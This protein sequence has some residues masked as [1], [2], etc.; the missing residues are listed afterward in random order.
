MPQTVSIDPDEIDDLAR[1]AA[2]SLKRFVSEASGTAKA[3]GRTVAGA[4]RDLSQ[5]P[6]K[7]RAGNAAV[8]DATGQPLL[9]WPS[10]WEAGAQADSI[11]RQASGYWRGYLW[12]HIKNYLK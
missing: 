4:V 2:T 5:V 8:S 1:E 10:A 3:A 7:V 12:P 9:R 11:L 6:A